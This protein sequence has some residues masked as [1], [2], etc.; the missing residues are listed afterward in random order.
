M[1][2]CVAGDV[3]KNF[4]TTSGNATGQ[5]QTKAIARYEELDWPTSLARLFALSFPA[6]RK[7]NRYCNQDGEQDGKAEQALLCVEGDAV[8]AQR[9]QIDGCKKDNLGLDDHNITH[10]KFLPRDGDCIFVQPH[11]GNL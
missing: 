11:V 9:P 2:S 10:P 3:A 5:G 1:S 6:C 4:S 8:I 7:D